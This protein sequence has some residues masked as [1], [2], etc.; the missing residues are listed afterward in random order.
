MRVLTPGACGITRPRR[1]AQTCAECHGARVLKLPRAWLLRHLQC[2]T[3]AVVEFSFDVVSAA[4]RTRNCTKEG[5]A[6]PNFVWNA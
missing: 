1:R 4:V 6:F 2:I 3:D 5:D